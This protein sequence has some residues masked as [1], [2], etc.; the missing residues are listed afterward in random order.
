MD[1]GTMAG[2]VTAG[3]AAAVRDLLAGDP[4]RARERAPDGVSVLLHALYRGRTDLVELLRPGA[5]PLDLHEAA[6]LGDTGRL[7]ALAAAGTDVGTPS[8]DGFTALHL[9]AFLGGPAAVAIL[10]ERGADPDAV[11]A[12]PMR[13]TPLHSAV[14]ARDAA[15]VEALLAAGA[16]ADAVQAG[17]YTPLM[18]AAHNGDE[19]SVRAL[20]AAGADPDRPNDAGET[21]RDLADPSL[22]P[23]PARG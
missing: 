4:E 13:V 22:R 3:D 10:L 20:L 17:G 5:G 1:V 23:L 6:A 15:S 14:A 12:N 9:A 11:A 7:G 21:A 19:R 18:G 2:A 16:T 8:P